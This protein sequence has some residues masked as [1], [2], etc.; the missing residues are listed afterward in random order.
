MKKDRKP[1]IAIASDHA[2]LDLKKHLVAYLRARGHKVLDLGP[3]SKKSVPYPAF[4]KKVAEMVAGGGVPLG[5]LICGTGIGMSITANRCP[6]VRAALVHDNYTARM[7]KAHNNAN[8]LVMGG[9]VIGPG[10]AEDAVE[11]WLS[12]RFEGGRHQ[13]RLDMIDAEC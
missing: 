3:R 8:V 2:A 6:G 12:T 4:G 7:A 10:V 11:T 5:I 1:D 13:E 9:R